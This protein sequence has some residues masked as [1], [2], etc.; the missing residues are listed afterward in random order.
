[1]EGDLRPFNKGL[2]YIQFF[3]FQ[4][5][6]SAMIHIILSSEFTLKNVLMMSLIVQCGFDDVS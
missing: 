3:M 4:S 1:M 2:F 6:S 5:S